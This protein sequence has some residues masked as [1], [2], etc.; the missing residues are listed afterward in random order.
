MNYRE[1]EFVG[2]CCWRWQTQPGLKI[3][4][5]H[6]VCCFELLP[7]AFKIDLKCF[8]VLVVIPSTRRRVCMPAERVINSTLVSSILWNKS[9]K[10]ALL[11]MHTSVSP[12]IFSYGQENER[13]S[14]WVSTK[15]L[16]LTHTEPH[17]HLSNGN[18]FTLMFRLGNS[19]VEFTTYHYRH[20]SQYNEQSLPFS[21]KSTLKQKYKHTHTLNVCEWKWMIFLSHFLLTY[22]I[23]RRRH[24]LDVYKRKES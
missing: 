13:R 9:P 7:N 11:N 24:S 20:H 15:G 10:W 14:G 5:K 19:F 23:L 3:G 12:F 2:T 8:E 16:V 17:Q 21:L 6:I 22:L 1:C 4:N 18:S